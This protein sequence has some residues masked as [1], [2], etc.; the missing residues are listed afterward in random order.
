MRS[1]VYTQTSP[2]CWRGGVPLCGGY[3][4]DVLHGL[5][6]LAGQALGKRFVVPP[7]SL[8]HARVALDKHG[9]KTRSAVPGQLSHKELIYDA[10]LTKQAAIHCFRRRRHDDVVCGNIVCSFPYS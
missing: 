6:P 3:G 9:M 4:A 1:R 10:L 2:A 8:S 7:R 5:W